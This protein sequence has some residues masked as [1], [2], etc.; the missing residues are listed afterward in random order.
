MENNLTEYIKNHKKVS[1]SVIVFCYKSDLI[2]R[3]NL[4][5]IG[6]KNFSLIKDDLNLIKEFISDNKDNILSYEIFKFSINQAVDLLDYD[7]KD[8]RI[9][10]SAVIR[11]KVEIGNKAVILMNSTINIGARI[12]D[13]TMIDMGAV[14]GSKAVIGNRCHIGANAVIAGVL[15]PENAK[16]VVIEDDVFIGANAVVLEGIR[17][18]HHSII[19]AMSLVNKDIPP[20][21]VVM[22]VPCKIIKSVDEKTYIKCKKNLKLH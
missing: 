10:P 11:E 19:G 12:G 2:N 14:I 20:Y 17:I 6:S 13:E 7:N 16:S 9:E 4:K 21:S 3:H 5:I 18:G 1:L 15:E 8:Y 22:G